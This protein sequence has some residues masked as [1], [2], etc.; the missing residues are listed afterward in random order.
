MRMKL[1]FNGSF[2]LA[3]PVEKAFDF[4]TDPS[5]IRGCIPDVEKFEILDDKNFN[6][7]I[8]VGVGFVR[9]SFDVKCSILESNRP[10]HSKFSIEG[11]GVPGKVK[12]QISFDLK[13]KSR[14]STLVNWTAD[15]ELGGLITG[16]G[17]TILRR[18]SESKV[19]E[20]LNRIKEKLE[21]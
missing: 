9:G 21:K 12:I 6:A 13:E 10:S 17:E 8:K 11:S 18:T 14:D 20:I 7:R 2:E 3:V 19:Q 15:S 16:L 1:N 5:S 4:L